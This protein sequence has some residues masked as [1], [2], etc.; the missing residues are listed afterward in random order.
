MT[1]C[2]HIDGGHLSGDPRLLDYYKPSPA[3]L[4]RP[5]YPPGWKC[6]EEALVS[7]NIGIMYFASPPP[8]QGTLHMLRTY[9]LVWQQPMNSQWMCGLWQPET[10]A[11]RTAATFG[12][13]SSQRCVQAKRPTLSVNLALQ[14]TQTSSLITKTYVI[15]LWSLLFYVTTFEGYVTSSRDNYC[16]HIL[17]LEN[18][19]V[20]GIN[21]MDEGLW[22]M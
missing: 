13:S 5:P 20:L 7:I 1:P 18:M 19:C 2:F 6:M 17:K 22:R 4:R 12:C 9:G 14:W 11:A 8:Q 10:P 3:D 21:P 16:I 15:L